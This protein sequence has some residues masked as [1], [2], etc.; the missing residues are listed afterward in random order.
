MP[1]GPE[2]PD[3]VVQRVP[4]KSSINVV[5]GLGLCFAVIPLLDTL[6]GG[7]N[8]SIFRLGRV[9]ESQNTGIATVHTFMCPKRVLV[10]GNERS[11][12]RICPQCGRVLYSPVGKR[13]VL[14]QKV[15]GI[16]V[17]E[18]QMGCLVVNETV[19][20]RVNAAAKWKNL[21]LKKLEVRDEPIDGFDIAI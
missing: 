21:G 5:F 4:D 10:R 20:Q 18:D 15:E 13:Y 14:R 12:Y 6:S 11:T 9:L 1:S 19:A 2:V 17:A 7:A 3:V 8:A 16:V